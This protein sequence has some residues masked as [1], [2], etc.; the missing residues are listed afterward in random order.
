MFRTTAY[1]LHFV[2]QM[3]IDH[4]DINPKNDALWEGQGQY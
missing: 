4:I 1:I 2:R 3:L